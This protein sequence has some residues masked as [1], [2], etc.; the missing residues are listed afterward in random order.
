[1]IVVLFVTLISVVAI[2]AGTLVK[3][4]VMGPTVSTMGDPAPT[5]K[6]SEKAH[7]SPEQ[8][9]ADC[10]KRQ[11]VSETH[12]A[13]PSQ[14]LPKKRKRAETPQR[15][16]ADVASGMVT[17]GAF[18]TR[19]TLRKLGIADSRAGLDVA[20]TG[21]ALGDYVRILH[22][23]RAWYTA[24]VLSVANGRLLAHYIG[25]DHS[26]NEWI[27]LDSKRLLCRGRWPG[28]ENSAEYA[29]QLHILDAEREA[30]DKDFDLQTE[31]DIAF[32]TK[33]NDQIK[34]VGSQ[35]HSKTPNDASKS[36]DVET[37]N[38]CKRGRPL[39]RHN[40]RRVGRV[41][42]R[43]RRKAK[44]KHP[45]LE[46]AS[47]D[48]PA[49]TELE[50]E[51]EPESKP[52]PE[53]E[54]RV[55]IPQE[56]R[57][58]RVRQL[59]EAANPYAR[60][61]RALVDISDLD[62]SSDEGKK[63]KT[64]ACAS[65]DDSASAAETAKPAEDGAIWDLLK[66]STY[67]TTGAYT[68]RRTIKCL[69]HNESI[70]GII[71][72]H[73]GFYPGQMVEVMNAN[74]KWYTG[75]II[76]YEKK[77][78]LV[79]YIGWNHAQNEW[80]AQG[81]KRLR[82]LDVQETEEEA[83]RV[84]ATLVDEYN[85]HIDELEQQR[86]EK[87]MAAAAKQRSAARE[88]VVPVNG[89]IAA[90]T[91]KAMRE[92]VA[93]AASGALT[94]AGSPDAK[95]MELVEDED[96]DSEVEP[97]SVD[98]GYSPV[99]QL[100]RVKDYVRCYHV[101][102]RVAA[103]DR[104]KLWWR[105]EIVDIKT[106]RFR[107]HYLGF[108]KV[109]DE[110]MEMNTQRVMIEDV[111]EP[112]DQSSSSCNPDASSEQH[113]AKSD[114]AADPAA[115]PPPPPIKKRLGR[116]PK[117][118]SQP[119]KMSLRLA[120]KA[121]ARDNG[122]TA[123]HHAVNAEEFELP[124]EH[125][126]LKEYGVFLRVGDKVRIRNR[127]MLWYECT[128]IDFKH[129]RI[130]VCFDGQSDEYNQWLVVNSDRIRVLR[131]TVEGD[132]RLEQLARES[133]AAQRRRKEKQ[134]EKRRRQNRLAGASLVRLAESLEYIINGKPDIQDPDDMPLLLRMLQ[135]GSEA[136]D[137]MPLALRLQLGRQFEQHADPEPAADS[138]TWFVYCNQCSVIIR[139]FRY[140]CTTCEQPSDGFD[141]VSFD[142][143][144]GCFS[145][146]FP[147]D[148]PHPR[149]AFA[150]AAVGD[151]DSIVAFTAR[152]LERCRN[153]ARKHPDAAD[154]EAGTSAASG[155]DN[156]SADVA[157]DGNDHPD[158]EDTADAKGTANTK[159]TA[160]ANTS[161]D[162]N[163]SA[164]VSVDVAST[165][166]AIRD[167]VDDEIG[168]SLSHVASLV[169]GVLAI[170]EPDKFDESYDPEAEQA[171]SNGDANSHSLW[172]TLATGLHGTTTIQAAAAS[173]ISGSISKK[174]AGGLA[175]S[176]PRCA[177]CGNSDPSVAESLGGFAGNRPFVLETT[178]NN[179]ETRSQRFWAH[180][181]CARGSPE[182]LA[183]PTGAWY[184]VA[185]ALRRGRTIT[186]A[187]CHKR[188]ATIG[189]FHERC[190]RSYHAMCTGKQPESFDKGELFWC[191]KH[192][193]G[194]GAEETASEVPP[195]CAACSR[196][197]TSDLMWMVCLECPT[198]PQP[199][200][201]CFTCYESRDALASHPHKKRCFRESMAHAGGVTSSGRYLAASARGGRRGGRR[202]QAN[203][204]HYCRTRSARRWRRGYGG[205][206]MCEAC[207]SAAHSIGN[208]PQS[209]SL[210]SPDLLVEPDANADPNA[211]PVEVEALNPFGSQSTLMVEDYSQKIYF[212]RD[213][214]A[215][216]ARANDTETASNSAPPSQQPLGRLAS[217][218]PTDSM[219]FTLIVN[220]TYFDIPGR[221]PRWGSHSGT[222]YHGTWLPQTVRRALLRYTRR[223]E[224]VLSN[225]L[226]RG[227]DAIEC[228]LQ[229]RKCFGVDINPSAVALS[230]RNCSFSIAPDSDMSVEYRPVIMQG[231]ARSLSDTNWPG[232]GY[233]AVPE[234]FDHVLSHP[235]YKDC[236]LYSTNID[237]DLSRF[238]GPEEF[239]REMNKVAAQSWRLLKM[240]RHLTMGIGDN[241]AECF[242]IPVS[243]QL[244]RNYINYGFE[245]DELLVKR[246]R[247]CQAFGLGTYLCVQFDFLMFTHEFIA[248][249]RKVPREAVDKMH[250]AESEYEEHTDWGFHK[251]HHTE[252]DTFT[253]AVFLSA[254]LTRPVPP[255]PIE[256]KSVVMGSVWSFNKHLTYTFPQL[257]MSRMVERF[258]R[259]GSNWEEIGLDLKDLHTQ[260]PEHTSDAPQTDEDGNSD[261]DD[262]YSSN[263]DIEHLDNGTHA[264]EYERERLKQIQ[265]NREQ[266]LQLGLVSE[267]GE[268]STDTAHYRK[269]LAMPLDGSPELPLALIVVPHVP[270]SKFVRSH[271]AAYRQALVQITHDS[272]HRL[273]PSGLLILGTQ[274]V[275]DEEG[276]LWPLGM[277]VLEDVQRAVGHIR[278][279]LK[280]FIVVVENGYARKRDDAVSRESF[281]DERCI[282]GMEGP[283]IHVPIV[284]AYYMV[285]MKLK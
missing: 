15:P 48:Q 208:E 73:H 41:K 66:N 167:S 85:R 186:C 84:C 33:A 106:F 128:I 43:V 144:L 258:G 120:L 227:T 138:E 38:T 53:L 273:S 205:V 179:G 196:K 201:I 182:V 65:A 257:C 215:A 185:V 265:K 74:R 62:S 129:G 22:L 153:E 164:D 282:V 130:R 281:V 121:L 123:Q 117:V 134:R 187:S 189:C 50:P 103:R 214:C 233:F 131:Q 136:A 148:H 26:F 277:L 272:S 197:L 155:E 32:G 280:E 178:N 122:G 27:G 94:T 92:S 64:E 105:A 118:E 175:S 226:G 242:Y 108:S 232:A 107:I 28:G 86:L 14:A 217:Y 69:A 198:D 222:D 126:T 88:K 4:A 180:Y 212:T 207:F 45:T 16:Q 132:G 260:T 112:D 124:R 254:R 51:P 245:L 11:A 154:R 2:T 240:G 68:T 270:N 284:H 165:V 203:S 237:G 42:H 151:V 228:F 190:H 267:L 81:S 5:E 199:F 60:Q 174:L 17:T 31:I 110:W 229:S 12:S 173:R 58:A 13:F 83:R 274:D 234:S 25:W 95:D 230:Q 193:D 89:Q 104:N 158:A 37:H 143:C 246:Q 213:S 79:H 176:Y 111:K 87:R 247:Y 271:I 75:R 96:V 137:A 194:N 67:V 35:N 127:D 56:L 49:P 21:I 275:R 160:D 169:S 99:P 149:T 171:P 47:T 3:V 166:D 46:A 191:P 255:S 223:G 261:S 231:D 24:V 8:A 34:I 259:D 225:F 251:L 135:G 279:R 244:I 168:E 39:G 100:L 7:E 150:R 192:S 219:L 6:S 220:S 248:T 209:Q 204:C 183:S 9:S 90:L 252:E 146:Q 249:L 202:G 206:L 262:E 147:S 177:F 250:L 157:T 235:P 238:P 54:Y 97:I 170:Y 36:K 188:G 268:D 55:V 162:A 109:W 19:T 224:R 70:G 40:R 63:P 61:R 269:M 71:Q 181:A 210:I 139:T 276:K 1:M 243:Y 80:I 76:T 20:E 102:M 172:S 114:T 140:Y 278:L 236:V 211:E 142:L 152:V 163:A 78:F 200:S 18:L 119:V 256:R 283:D 59:P 239:Q 10:P 264:G 216:H 30:M 101:G 116:P 266:L 113:A 29:K 52:E 218:G 82:T 133:Q 141:Y 161:A 195:S 145:K 98:S 44:S 91:G 23:D 93:A 241:R 72:D 285:F 221:A 115:P 156:G 253:D 125:M 263:S 77:R 57:I 159:N 184:N